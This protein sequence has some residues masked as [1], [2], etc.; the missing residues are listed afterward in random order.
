MIKGVVKHTDSMRSQLAKNSCMT[1]QAIYSQLPQKELDAVVD[2][3]LTSLLK[4]ATDTNNFVSE[5]AD[6]ALAMVCHSCSESKVFTCLQ[7]I[8]NKGP[9]HRQ[10][11]CICYGHIIQKLGNKIGSFKECVSL[12]KAVV[13]MLSEGAQEVRNAAKLAILTIKNNLSSQREFDAL[14][15]RC[16]LTE[17]QLE[18]TKKVVEFGDIDQNSVILNTKYSQS[19]RGSSLD[20]KGIQ[21]QQRSPNKMMDGTDSS[22]NLNQSYI[23]PNSS[24]ANGF[25]ATDS[26]F[27]AFKKRQQ[28]VSKPTKPIDP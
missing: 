10:K 28:S 22:F 26:S 15:S 2:I 8:P 11:T 24:A 18:Q 6:K 3:V 21:A 25:Q 9:S 7:M 23:S 5:Q 20:S 12:V 13:N 17:K 16:G 14:M 27:V 19:M 1:L 4:K